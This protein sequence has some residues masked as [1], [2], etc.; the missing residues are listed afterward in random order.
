MCFKKWNDLQ[1]S[2]EYLKTSRTTA[3][4]QMACLTALVQLPQTGHLPNRT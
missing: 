2:T 4:S 1:K 3:L